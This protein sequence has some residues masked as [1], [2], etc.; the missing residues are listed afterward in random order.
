MC[1]SLMIT[2]PK[3]LKFAN[4]YAYSSSEDF[5]RTSI[6]GYSPERFNTHRI[7]E[8]PD[9]GYWWPCS[10]IEPRIKA[11]DQLIADY[12]KLCVQ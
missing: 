6:L 11:F 3:G 7:E 10:D 1:V 12:E 5:L 8:G 9:C 4:K 2:A